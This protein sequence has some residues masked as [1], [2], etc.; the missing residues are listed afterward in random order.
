MKRSSDWSIYELEEDARNDFDTEGDHIVSI[1]GCEILCKH[2]KSE[3]ETYFK[4]SKYGPETYQISADA[5]IS[6][7]VMTSAFD[8]VIPLEN[9]HSSVA[10]NFNLHDWLEIDN[11]TDVERMFREHDSTF[12]QRHVKCID[13]VSQVSCSSDMVDGSVLGYLNDILEEDYSSSSYFPEFGP[14]KQNGSQYSSKDAVIQRCTDQKIPT[15]FQWLA[16][17]FFFFRTPSSSYIPNFNSDAKMDY[18]LPADFIP[19]EQL[20]PS[21][22]KFKNNANSTTP[23]EHLVVHVLGHQESTVPSALLPDIRIEK[24]PEM[25]SYYSEHTEDSHHDTQTTKAVAEKF[26]SKATQG[27]CLVAAMSSHDV[28]EEALGFRQLWNVMIQL[29]VTTK[30]CIRDG[31][32]GL[33]EIAAQSNICS[34]HNESFATRE[35][36]AVAI[37]KCK[38]TITE[39]ERNSTDQSVAHLLFQK[40]LPFISSGC[41]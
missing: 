40:P 12:G 19:K 8:N 24:L 25:Q 36:D 3:H 2:K 29:N 21:S 17:D 31:L 35:M 38:K 20:T 9:V 11:F 32:Y 39:N 37:N 34:E 10:K 7:I 1:Q 4:K 28:F 18:S 5:A 23:Y 30:L 26:N 27:S 22:N 14:S 15:P 33:A 16:D 6:Y 13:E 41:F